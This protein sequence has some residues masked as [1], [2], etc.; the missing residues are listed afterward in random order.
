M[1]KYTT[2]I[3]GSEVKNNIELTDDNTA[4]FNGEI[5]NYDH[6]FLSENVIMLRI[7]NKNFFMTVNGTDDS[8][9]TG[10]TDI[11]LESKN[12]TLTCKSE[13]DLLKEKMSTGKGSSKL[14]KDIKSPMPGIIKSMNVV[15]DQQVKKGEI[16]LVLEAMK[17]ENEIKAVT[18]CVIKKINVDVMSSVEKNELLIELE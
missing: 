2:E 8:E 13:L 10:Q 6:K 18:D 4:I 17:M 9:I 3:T 5:I 16:L 11:D 14:K 15:K 7:K 1:N 12:Y